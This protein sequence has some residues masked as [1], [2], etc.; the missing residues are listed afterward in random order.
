[1]T[2]TVIHNK[3]HLMESL[4]EDAFVRGYVIGSPES[5]LIRK[6]VGSQGEWPDRL[7]PGAMI[8]QLTPKQRE[9]LQSLTPEDLNHRPDS[10]LFGPRQ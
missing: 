3:H 8:E 7:K 5:N 2:K 4:I 6:L 9:M 1:M 10:I